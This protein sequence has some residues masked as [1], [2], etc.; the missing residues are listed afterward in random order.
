MDLHA[1]APRLEDD[2]SSRLGLALI[3]SIALHAALVAAV[4]TEAVTFGVPQLIRATLVPVSAPG[5]SRVSPPTESLQPAELK[6]AAAQPEAVDPTGGDAA[7]SDRAAGHERP[8]D[9]DA[10][11]AAAPAYYY[12]SQDVDVRATPMKMETTPASEK[13]VLLGRLVRVKL[14]L[15]ISEQGGVDRFEILEAEG[16]TDAVSLEDVSEIRFHPAQKAG[17]PVKSQK[18]VELTFAP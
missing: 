1:G 16:L 13:N 18:V 12:S 3:V 9:R 11:F 10:L 4:R 15:F 17:R 6:T 7:R 14:R 2:G 5:P 8:R